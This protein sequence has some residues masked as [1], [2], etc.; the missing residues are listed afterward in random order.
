MIAKNSGTRNHVLLAV[1]HGVQKADKQLLV[2]LRAE[3]AL[4]AEICMW[5]DVFH[6][7]NA[8][9]IISMA[10][11]QYFYGFANVNNIK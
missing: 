4:K 7:H 6:Y 2:E 8:A 1:K 9:F 5:I 10:N 11:I 3:Q